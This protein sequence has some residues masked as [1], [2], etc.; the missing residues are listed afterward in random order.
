MAGALSSIKDT[1]PC[2]MDDTDHMQ[3]QVSGWKSDMLRQ[4][5]WFGSNL[6]EGVSIRMDLHTRF[7]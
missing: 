1:T 5:L 2:K 6:P 4:I 7:I 3:F